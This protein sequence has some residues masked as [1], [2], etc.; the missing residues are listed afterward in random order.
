MREM[1]CKKKII[2]FFVVFLGI[3][4]N[5]YF[6]ALGDEINVSS[7]EERVAID[8][9]SNF[10]YFHLSPNLSYEKCLSG[11]REYYIH[12]PQI[13]Y[14]NTVYKTPNEAG[15]FT[16]KFT[17]TSLTI[18]YSTHQALYLNFELADD[19]PIWSEINENCWIPF[20]ESG[21][22]KDQ[23]AS[24]RAKTV[25]ESA[26]YLLGDFSQKENSTIY[27]RVPIDLTYYSQI[28]QWIQDGYAKA[29][30]VNW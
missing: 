27:L 7:E 15:G 1:I 5:S 9:I 21:F 17:G 14:E 20:T 13:M 12:L 26:I 19:D 28:Q 16:E 4:F 2:V 6:Y 11:L 29:Y 30:P 25:L 22:E 18:V 10:L 8:K 23:H 3:A 24:I